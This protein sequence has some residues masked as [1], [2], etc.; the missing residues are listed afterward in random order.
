MPI[1]DS[2]HDEYEYRR[3]CPC[4]QSPLQQEGEI[5]EQ[6]VR[7][8]AIA[9]SHHSKARMSTGCENPS[10]LVELRVYYTDI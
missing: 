7:H 2:Q 9:L 6:N 8:H 3:Q 1:I 5:G 4:D 10:A